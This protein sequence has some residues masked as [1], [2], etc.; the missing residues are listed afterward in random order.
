MAELG[1]ADGKAGDSH[2]AGREWQ[3]SSHKRKKDWWQTVHSR[4]LLAGHFFYR[5]PRKIASFE[6]L[7]SSRLCRGNESQWLGAAGIRFFRGAL[8]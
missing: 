3:A 1:A 6:D 8:K 5:G 2:N 4:G 7:G